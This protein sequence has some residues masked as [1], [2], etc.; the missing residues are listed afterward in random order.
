MLLGKFYEWWHEK[1]DEVVH[2]YDD[3]YG[4]IKA[5][6]LGLLD[7]TL[8]AMTLIGVATYGVLIAKT[9]KRK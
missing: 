9:F 8:S 7:G 4:N 6:G 5:I 3:R 1:T 2:N